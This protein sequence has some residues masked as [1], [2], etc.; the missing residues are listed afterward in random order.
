[1][2]KTFIDLESD[3]KIY[4]SLTQSQGQLRFLTGMKNKIKTFVQWTRNLIRMGMNPDKET[5]SLNQTASLIRVY[6]TH[7]KFIKDSSL[8]PDPAKPNDLLIPGRDKVP[9]YML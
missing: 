4:S 2:Y 9:L 6:K 7:E 1:M 5:F 8:Q 3:F